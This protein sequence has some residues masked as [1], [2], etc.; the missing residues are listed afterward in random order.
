MC[1]TLCLRTDA[2][3][4][5]AKNS[6]RPPREVQV[7]LTHGPRRAGS[8]LDTQYL[9]IA[10]RDAHA[11]VG[12]H[13]DWLW[14]AEHGV[15]EH[16][17][18]IGNEKIWTVDDPHA[19]ATGLLGMDLV[20]LGLE[21][22]RNADEA[23]DAVIEALE[24]SGQGGSGEPGTDEPYF[25]SFLIVDA[26]GGWIVETSAR[27][28]AARPVGDGSSISNRVS[29]G[30]DWTRAS[31]DV[32]P[33]TDFDARRAPDTPTWIAD[34]R[35]AATRACVARRTLGATDQA[36]ADV[37]ATLRDH[38]RGPWGAPG[39]TAPSIGDP[40]PTLVAAPT[41]A[42]SVSVCMHL[43]DYQATTASM[44]VDLRAGEP[45]RAWA[46]LGSPCASVYVPCFPPAV[47]DVLRDPAQWQRFARLR[48]RVE[49]DPEGLAQ[50]RAVLGPI[51]RELWDAADAAHT[52][53][54]DAATTTFVADA[55]D[56]VTSGLAAL[57]V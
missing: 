25:S 13:P 8:T 16:G 31:A 34:H 18:A 38:G 46:C 6:D 4:V 33:G 41:E 56:R 11:F 50:V 15:N 40:V 30:T 52:A 7:L 22:G 3:M 19:Q 48:E 42:E 32:A 21:R 29:L 26:R 57:G 23:L 37:V 36:V 35:L 44:V 14:G 51:E 54:T 9:R 28:W 27:S 2:G 10:D 12:S 5:F 20:R 55:S 24:A 49:T 43:R 45:V 1:D 17:V 53:G 47:P 39:A